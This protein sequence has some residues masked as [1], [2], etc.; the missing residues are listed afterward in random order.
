[1]KEGLGLEEQHWS[2]DLAA[3]LCRTTLT[4]RAFN[5]AQ[6][7]RSRSGQRLAQMGIRRLRRQV[8]RQVGRAPAV[9]FLEDC[10]A[11]LS[12]EELWAA[13]G[14]GVGQ[15]L[16]PDLEGQTVSAHPP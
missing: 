5:T 12:L 14:V 6:V 3:A 10:Y 9:V 16:L 2:R 4:L 13:V 1:M 15:G 8:D 7:H 11:V